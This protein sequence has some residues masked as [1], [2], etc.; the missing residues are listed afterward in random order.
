MEICPVWSLRPSFS[1]GSYMCSNY[2][3]KYWASSDWVV[4]SRCLGKWPSVFWISD[5]LPVFHQRLSSSTRSNTFFSWKGNKEQILNKKLSGLG[6]EVPLWGGHCAN[7][8][9]Q[10]KIHRLEENFREACWKARKHS[11][12]LKS[13]CCPLLLMIT[14]SNK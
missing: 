14:A 5:H 12:L 2:F 9:L 10:P 11:W 4:C 1:S 3:Q 6:L 7:S 13:C 8:F